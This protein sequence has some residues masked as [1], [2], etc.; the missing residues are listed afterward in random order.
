MAVVQREYGS[1]KPSPTRLYFDKE[2]IYLLGQIAALKEL[3]AP[4]VKSHAGPI[5]VGEIHYPE[6]VDGRIHQEAFKMGWDQMM[7]EFVE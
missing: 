7:R 6:Q 2:N 1:V 4:M 3:V 5:D